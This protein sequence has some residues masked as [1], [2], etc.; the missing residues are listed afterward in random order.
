MN[1]PTTAASISIALTGLLASSAILPACFSGELSICKDGVYCP[2]NT[3]CALGFGKF[4]CV[5]ENGCGNSRLDPGEVCDDGNRLDDDGCNHNCTLIETCG[6]GIV[7]RDNGEVCDDRNTD[8]GDGCS[9]DCRSDETCG[10]GVT[11]RA[12]GE[13]CDAE[14]Q[15]VDQC[16][17][18]ASCGNQYL[19]RGE[20]CDDGNH[21]DRDGCSA[22]CQSDETCGNAIIDSIL[23]EHCDAGDADFD[24]IPD[25]TRSCDGDCTIPEC[26]D[27]FVN[28]L[29]NPATEEPDDGEECDGG[30]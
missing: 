25:T 1:I 6:N 20:A 2:P 17:R 14:P 3:V 7:D 8:A 29:V 28:I 5:P 24:R 10:N 27:G 16:S 15:C 11:D 26:G 30:A 4:V 22:D 13:V 19:D 21:T 9:A 12:V 18:L 23:G